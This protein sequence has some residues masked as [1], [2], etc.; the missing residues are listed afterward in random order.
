MMYD[1]QLIRSKF[2]RRTGPR[3]GAYDYGAKA[4][5]AAAVAYLESLDKYPNFDKNGAC[6]K[7]A[8]SYIAEF[9]F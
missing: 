4:N 3:F 5:E 8:E 9:D 2:D 7:A 1:E 6:A